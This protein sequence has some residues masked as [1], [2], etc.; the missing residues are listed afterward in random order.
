ML[1]V[2]ESNAEKMPRLLKELG[3][4][5]EPG[6]VGWKPG[7]VAKNGQTAMALAY[8]DS[9]DV[10]DRL[11]TLVMMGLIDSW[12][13]EYEPLTA[14]AVRCRLFLCINGQWIPREDVGGASGQ[15]DAGDKVKAAFS[16]ALKRAAVK[17]GIGRY[18][19]HLDA[20][21]CDYDS[22]KKKFTRTPKLPDWALPN[23]S[24][25]PASYA[26][27]P[28]LVAAEHHDEVTAGPLPGPA[29]APPKA[30]KPPPP[31][32]GAELYARLQDFDAAQAAKKVFPRGA[33]LVHVTQAGVK[34]GYSANV[35][36][37]T[38]PAI[39]FGIDTALD[40][41]NAQ[42]AAAQKQTAAK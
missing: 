8:I 27:P 36:E 24:G 21:W 19:Y 20:P 32:N 41:F 26:L 7:S 12:K 38:G 33:M 35:T 23:G 14:G 22:Q 11:D 9:R 25:R 39:Q 13:D 2:N 15:P 10:M 31:K 5:F 30:D 29:A 37:W 40:F 4:P 17:W 28:H 42:K 18:L 6:C 3:K 1:P 34:A 16:D